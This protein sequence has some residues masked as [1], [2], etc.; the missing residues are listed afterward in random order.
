M[1][2]SRPLGSLVAVELAPTTMK[3]TRTYRVIFRVDWSIGGENIDHDLPP[4]IVRG[5]D[6]VDAAIQ[7]AQKKPA[8]HFAALAKGFER[9]TLPDEK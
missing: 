5:R 2:V 6:G 8:D 1:P 9:I 7:E 4:V 3:Q